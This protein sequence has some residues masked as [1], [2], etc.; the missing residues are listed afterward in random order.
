MRASIDLNADLGEGCDDDETLLDLVSS[1]SIACGLHAG[2][3][4]LML[5]TVRSA[6][7]RGVTVGAHPSYDDREGFGRRDLQMEQ[8]ELTAVVAYQI[9]A[10]RA[11]AG[12]A[13]TTVGFV[14]PHGALYNRA[15]IEEAV[16]DAVTDAITVA[17]GQ[18]PAHPS[19]GVAALPVLCQP[20]SALAKVAARK[21]VTVLAEAFADRGYRADGTL[22]PRSH[23]GAILS[24]P[25]AAAHQ[26]V[27][28]A[29][30]G[31]VLADDGTELA[32]EAD[33]ICVHGDSPQAV[34]VARAVRAALEDAGIPVRPFA[35]G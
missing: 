17:V 6:A 15:S 32:L 2:S 31:T 4:A 29:K 24:D 30:D 14:K 16:A 28:L 21:G 19:G 23:P 18:D 10:M 22:L 26:A 3:P 5:R 34:A 9:G 11:V 27:R 13:G 12:A 20:G 7:S 33:S 8:D 35:P 1:A 25:Q